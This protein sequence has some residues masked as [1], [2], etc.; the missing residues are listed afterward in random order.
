MKPVVKLLI[1]FGPLVV[2]IIGNKFAG[3]FWGTGLFMVAVLAALLANWLLAGKL[4]RMLVI[5]AIAVMIFGGLTIWLHEEFYIQ[6]KVTVLNALIGSVLLG[7]LMLGRPILK[8]MLD[9]AVHL[10]DF[11][12]RVLTLR[13]GLFFFAVAGLNEIV[14]RGVSFDT[15]LNFKLVGLLALT[16]LFAFANAPYMAKHMI[17]DETPRP[18]APSR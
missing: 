12:W 2:F 1:E 4:S 14:R 11:A 13:W 15:W 16:M 3:P 6:V 5:T 7:G 17:E 9:M 10:P 18:D 8:D